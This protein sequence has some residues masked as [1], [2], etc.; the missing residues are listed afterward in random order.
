MIKYQLANDADG[1]AIGVILFNE[2]GSI[3]TIDP[4]KKECQQGWLQYQ[5]WLSVAGNCPAAATI[6]TTLEKK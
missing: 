1:N 3:T 6:E 4:T 5:K 2:D